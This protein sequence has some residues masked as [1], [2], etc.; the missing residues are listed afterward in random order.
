[1]VTSAR[2]LMLLL[3]GCL[4]LAN[5]AA[6]QS[7]ADT[8]SRWGLLGTWALDCT[9]PA[10]GSNGY[11]TYVIRGGGRVSHERDFGDRRDANDVQ[12]AKTRAGGALEI[13]VHFPQLK[14]TR[15]YTLIMGPDRR[16][17]A[18]AN[19][20]IDGTEETIKDGKFIHNGAETPWQVRCR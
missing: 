19:S 12:Q 2:T 13:V 15:K 6:A 14:Q 1:M 11:L 7:V 5:G 3:A 18:M 16:T 20:R 17:R 9:K 4:A 8:V 10:S